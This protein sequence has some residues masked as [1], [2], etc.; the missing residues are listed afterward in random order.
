MGWKTIIKPVGAWKEAGRTTFKTD[1]DARH[2]EWG[3]SVVTSRATRRD[4]GTEVSLIRLAE[5]ILETVVNRR[6]PAKHPAGSPPPRVVMK[7]D[8]EGSER[9]VVPDLI[10]SGALSHIDKV[11]VIGMHHAFIVPIDVRS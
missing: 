3:G 10:V 7:L 9:V 8:I 4:T 2:E 6:L 5:Y 1:D 11:M